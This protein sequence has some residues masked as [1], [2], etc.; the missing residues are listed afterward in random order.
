MNEEFWRELS[1]KLAVIRRRKHV[2]DLL[3]LVFGIVGTLAL[4]VSRVAYWGNRFS[5]PW[6]IVAA[7]CMTSM[8]L[9]CAYMEA[10]I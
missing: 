4:L 9:I 2:R 3:L 1:S 6:L 5:W 10:D 8:L 7:I